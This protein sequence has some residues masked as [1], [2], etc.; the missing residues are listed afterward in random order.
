MEQLIFV[1]IMIIA[2]MNQ[3]DGVAL[4]GAKYVVMGDA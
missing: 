4:M 2:Q 3:K 1:Q